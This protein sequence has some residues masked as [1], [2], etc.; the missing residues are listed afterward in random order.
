MQDVKFF[1]TMKI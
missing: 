1:M